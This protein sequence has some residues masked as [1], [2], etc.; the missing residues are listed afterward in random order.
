MT[1]IAYDPFNGIVASDS[2]ET[3]Y[4]RKN[5]CK[6][7]FRV[8]GHIIGTSGGTFAGLLFIEWFG[9]YEDEP[10]WSERPDLINLDEECEGFECLVV[11]SDGTCYLINRLFVPYEQSIK[12]FVCLGSGSKVALGALKAGAD[13]KEAIKIACEVDAFSS[14]KVQVMKV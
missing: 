4:G 3:G 10:E 6:K 1:T 8:N 5:P 14:G 7:L 11:R 9:E 12:D 2:Q 13:I